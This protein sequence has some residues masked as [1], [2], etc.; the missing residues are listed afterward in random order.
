M[1]NLNVGLGLAMC[2]VST[3]SAYLQVSAGSAVG[4]YCYS[5][6]EYPGDLLVVA[7]EC[8]GKGYTVDDCS[9]SAPDG[10]CYLGS[11]GG[12]DYYC[13][14]GGESACSF[15]NCSSGYSEWS[16]PNSSGVVT[17]TYEEV[18][19]SEYYYCNISQQTQYGCAAGYFKTSGS[20]SY[21]GTVYCT[22]CPAHNTTSGWVYG[23]TSTGNRSDATAC[24]LPAGTASSF[25]DTKGSGTEK[26]TSTC[27]YSN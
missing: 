21:S 2:C 25:S 4:T 27:Y 9:T 14:W 23:N 7:C 18:D 16:S 12:V 8:D 11:S 15:C 10:T 22:T 26:F 3:A 5:D 19:D 17:R 6:W 13:D 1:P 20:S 24:W